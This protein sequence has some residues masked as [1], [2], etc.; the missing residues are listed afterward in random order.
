MQKR[1]QLQHKAS[2]HRNERNKIVIKNE[3]IQQQNKTKNVEN[4]KNMVKKLKQ[5]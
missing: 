5:I 4:G 1:R 3:E 2:T